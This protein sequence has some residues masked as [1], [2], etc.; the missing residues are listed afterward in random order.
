ME[1]DSTTTWPKRGAPEEEGSLLT[2]DNLSL[3]VR[4]HYTF[5]VK[6]GVDACAP[7]EL[8][9]TANVSGEICDVDATTVTTTV[10]RAKGAEPCGVCVPEPTLSAAGKPV[11]NCGTFLPCD[12]TGQGDAYRTLEK[13]LERC[14]ELGAPYAISY[15]SQCSCAS[16]QNNQGEVVGLVTT[17]AIGTKPASLDIVEQCPKP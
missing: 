12:S 6:V 16:P 3:A 11:Y 17:Y 2:W 10:K 14:D 7:D 1:L 8:E 5:R 13:C 9:F 15:E 4:K